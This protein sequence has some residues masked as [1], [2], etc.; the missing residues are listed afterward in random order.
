MDAKKKESQRVLK[1]K[2]RKK[3]HKPLFEEKLKEIIVQSWV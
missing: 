2:S 3:I 1:G